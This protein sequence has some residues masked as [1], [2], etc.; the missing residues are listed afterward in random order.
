MYKGRKETCYSLLNQWY[1]KQ[2]GVKILKEKNFM[3]DVI[4]V[5]FQ[6]AR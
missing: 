2:M 3:I 5:I 1:H 6:G 4:I